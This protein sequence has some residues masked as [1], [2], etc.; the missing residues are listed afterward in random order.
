M[1]N[2]NSFLD[3]KLRE[4]P[5]GYTVLLVALSFLVIVLI[6]TFAL[7]ML[8]MKIK[9]GHW[10]YAD[11][12][13]TEQFYAYL[14]NPLHVKNTLVWA[15]ATMLTQLALQ[16]NDKFGQGLLWDF[17]RG[18]YQNPNH[19]VRIFM[20]LD[21]TS[22]TAIAEQL[23]NLNY[24]QLL[25][26]FYADI[27]NSIIYNGGKIYQYVGDEVIISWKYKESTV[28]DQCLQ[29]YF[30]IRE[31]IS[32]LQQKY[33]S[34]YGLVPDFK[35]AI[36]YGAVT[37]GEI[38]IIKRD[39][40]YSGDVLNT[41]SRMLSKCKEYGKKLL[42]SGKLFHYLSREEGIFQFAKMGEDQLRGKSEKIEIYAVNQ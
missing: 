5:Y 26:D 17:I 29:C 7:G 10:P 8:F 28:D 27:T 18:K 36:H 25:K 34:R 13:A 42:V 11:V 37:A 24:Y 35:A 40:T 19:E 2:S 1:L 41:T 4:A 3:E 23:G 14:R 9:T 39:I 31:K 6:I 15:N 20:F 30:D 21:L 33:I 22:S 38:G 32:S 12:L 16:I